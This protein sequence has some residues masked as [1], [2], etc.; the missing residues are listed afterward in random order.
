MREHKSKSFYPSGQD[1]IRGSMQA[2]AHVAGLKEVTGS[3]Q[4]AKARCSVLHLISES[5]CANQVV[6]HSTAEPTRSAGAL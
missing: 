1:G 5:L 2:S 3:A 4:A 6:Q